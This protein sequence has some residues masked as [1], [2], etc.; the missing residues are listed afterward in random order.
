MLRIYKIYNFKLHNPEVNVKS[1]S[2]SSRPGDLGIYLQFIIQESKD[3]YY[4]MDS[5][6]VVLES[7]LLNWNKTNYNYLHYSSLPTCKIIVNKF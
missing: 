4:V 1:M 6:I 2:F 5:K 3:D 7:S